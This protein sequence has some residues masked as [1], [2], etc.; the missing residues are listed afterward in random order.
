MVFP[1]SHSKNQAYEGETEDV[2]CCVWQ[3]HLLPRIKMVLKKCLG[4]HP[5]P[6]LLLP[7]LKCRK[8]MKIMPLREKVSCQNA[9]VDHTLPHPSPRE[10]CTSPK[11]WPAALRMV[12][13][14]SMA[15]GGSVPAAPSLLPVQSW[16]C[17]GTECENCWEEHQ[18]MPGLDASCLALKHRAASRDSRNQPSENSAT[19]LKTRVIFRTTLKLCGGDS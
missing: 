1:R 16:F 4:R 5:W 13:G 3:G 15:A 6:L 2:C 18:V 12:W 14:A 10:E 7:K 17:G 11:H 19:Q 9:G 8:T